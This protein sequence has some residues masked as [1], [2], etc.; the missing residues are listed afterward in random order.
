[1]LV[2]DPNNVKI[3]N[4]SAGKSLPEWLSDRKRRA[5]LKKNVDIRRRIELIQDFE[6]PALSTTVRVSK[7]GE[8]V[9]ATG[10]YKPRVRCYDVNNLSMKF[11]RCFDADVVTFEIL[12]DDYSKL[13]FLHT[14]RYVEFHSAQGHYHRLRIPKFGRDM[15][16]HYP[17]CDLYIVGAGP[18]VYRL[19]LE[20]GQFLNPL[21]TEASEVD[22]CAINPLHNLLVCGTKEGKVEA[23]D[24]RARDRIGTLDCALHCVSESISSSANVN[25]VPFGE[26][27]Q[28]KVWT[29]FP[30]ASGSNVKCGLCSI[31][32]VAAMVEG[33]SSVSALKFKGGLTLGVGTSTGQV[34]LYDIRSNKP[35]Y[36][37]DHMY[38]LPIVNVDFHESQDLVLSMDECIVK[39]WDKN[40]GK[41]FTSIEASETKFHSLCVVPNTGMMFIANENTKILTY[42]IPSLGPA[43]KWCSFLDS[44]TE[45]LEESTMETVYDDYK[46]VTKRELED[47]GLEH[48]LGTNLLRAYMHGYFVDIRLYKKAKM[49]AEPFAFEEYRKKKIHQKI[50]ENRANR[51]LPKVNKDLALKLMDEDMKEKKKK[52][53]GLSLLKDD[54]FKMLFENPD[55][56]VDKNAEEFRLLNPVLSKLDKSRKKELKKQVLQQQFDEIEEEQ[57][58]KPSSE[59]SSDDSGSSSGDDREWTKN[60]KRQHKVLKNEARRKEWEERRKERESEAEAVTNSGG[61]PK[62]FELREGEEFKG[63]HGGVKRKRNNVSLGERVKREGHDSVRMLGSVG[64][65]EMTFSVRKE[66]RRLKEE[67]DAQHHYEER[68]K[69]LRPAKGLQTKPLPKFL[70]EYRR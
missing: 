14:D 8:Y 53:V 23:W 56:Q 21:M 36:T 29:V 57:E 40:T 31:W 55:F 26:W 65:R 34:L 54:R 58:G 47:L 37:K 18:E 6:M 44:L 70:R 50:E 68:K 27:Q 11:E 3:Y 42:Y 25:C 38:G 61:Q 66:Q 67:K 5:L 28:C 33:V 60:L 7:D 10:T 64:N 4:L 59:E 30:L 35:F 41:L 20:R 12:S 16:Y 9:L 39:I 63:I 49:V 45:E 48:L 22:C 43:P 52:K 1:M 62:F 24:P 15:Q 46:F 17:T 32:R 51:K 69:L 19:N 13:V 2:S